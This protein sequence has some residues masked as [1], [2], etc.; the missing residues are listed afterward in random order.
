VLE[1]KLTVT[2]GKDTFTLGPGDSPHFDQ[3][4]P[5]Q[6]SNAGKRVLRILWV[7]TPAIF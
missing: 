3:R 4:H 6:M 5:F 1:G 2:L 7:G